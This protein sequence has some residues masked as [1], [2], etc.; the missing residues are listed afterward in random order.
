MDPSQA[1]TPRPGTARDIDQLVPLWGLVYDGS[2]DDEATWQEPARQWF[3][4]CV[5]HREIACFPVIEVDDRIV[6]S[7][8][9]TL[10]LGVPNPH[11]PHGRA[12]RLANVFTLPAHRR[13]GYGAALVGFVVDWAREIGADRVDLSATPDGQRLY[14]RSGFVPTSA[15]RMK[16]ML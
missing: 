5:D 3:S 1:P 15:P 11:C 13:R 10:E 16:L 4:R 7:A 12:V 9:G 8:V 14:E 2:A 6:A